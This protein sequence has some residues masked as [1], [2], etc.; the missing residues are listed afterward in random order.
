MSHSSIPPIVKRPPSIGKAD[1]GPLPNLAEGIEEG[2]SQMSMHHPHF[3]TGHL[4]PKGR[5]PS[6]P[7]SDQPTEGWCPCNCPCVG[8]CS[9]V[10]HCTGKAGNPPK[11]ARYDPISSGPVGNGEPFDKE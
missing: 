8:P 5:S 7:G 9:C 4:T 1:K 10:G 3:T 2:S 11:G 6:P